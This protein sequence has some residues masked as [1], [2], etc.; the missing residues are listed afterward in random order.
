MVQQLETPYDETDMLCH[1]R[2]QNRVSPFSA[3]MEIYQLGK[4]A[5]WKDSLEC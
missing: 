3:S 2:K 1:P 4:Q 5:Y